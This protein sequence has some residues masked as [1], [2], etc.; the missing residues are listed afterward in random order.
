MSKEQVMDRCKYLLIVVLVGC[1]PLGALAS[2]STDISEKRT[3]VAMRLIGH[4]LLKCWGDSTSRVLPIEHID[5][6][7]QISFEFEFG[8]DP[9]DLV[10]VIDLKNTLSGR[11]AALPPKEFEGL[12]RPAFQQDEWILITVGAALGFLAGLAQLVFMFS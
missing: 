9:R 5:Q 4:E 10:N 11:L 6:Q 1:I 8:F 3:A 7:Y 2:S 12:L